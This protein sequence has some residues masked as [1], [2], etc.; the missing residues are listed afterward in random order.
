MILE[1]V[2]PTHP[3]IKT[4][5]FQLIERPYAISHKDNPS[6]EEHKN[7]VV[8]HPYRAWFIINNNDKP[9]GNVYIHTDN[10]IGLN[11]PIEISENEIQSILCMI[12]D[13]FPPLRGIP[14]VR[15]GN[16]FLNVSTENVGLQDKLS[17]LGLI[18]SQRTYV[19]PVNERFSD[20]RK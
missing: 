8:N 2:E 6:F 16:Y 18:E 14:S 15:Y 1:R 5:F 3:Q 19:F 4:L 7:F 17:N 11:C 13:K 10:S 12:S 20:E 9:I